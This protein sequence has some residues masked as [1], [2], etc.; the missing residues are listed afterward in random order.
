[1]CLVIDF[2]IHSMKNRVVWKVFDRQEGRTVSLYQGAVY[3]KGKLVIRDA[4]NVHSHGHGSHGLHF[5]TS[6]SLAKRHAKLW[7]DAYI[8]KFTVNPLDF[9]FANASGEEA[10]YE[11]ATRVG[12]YIRVKLAG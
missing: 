5:F 9:M 10:M 3:P 12:N 2:S 4:G 11:K 1:M 6:K 7:A 8:A